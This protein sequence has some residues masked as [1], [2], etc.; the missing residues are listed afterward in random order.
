MDAAI[1]IDWGTSNLRALLFDAHG[2]IRDERERPWGIR[3]LPGGDF[4]RALEDVCD[5][6]PRAPIVASGM[7]G[8]RQGWR[9]ANYV[10]T[11]ADLHA[12]ARH[13]TTFKTHGGRTLAIVPGVRDATKPDVMR[14]EE[15]EIMGALALCPD[16]AAAAQIVLPGTHSKWV[17]VREGKI[18]GFRTMM[19]GEL[20]ALLIRHSILGA[21]IPAGVQPAMDGPAFDAGVRAACAAGNAGALTRIFSARSLVLEK[22]LTPDSVP[23][24]LSGLL[25]G[26]EWRAMSASGWLRRGASLLLVGDARH[27]ALYQRAAT[28]FDLPQPAALNGAAARGLWQIHALS[29]RIDEMAPLPARGH[30]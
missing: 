1:G 19:T 25:I 5:G 8:S 14:G 13:M 30:V 4:E 21:T 24:Y 10:D 20:H 9:E 2:E 16:L 23:S 28:A 3:Q 6:W 17:D 15:T 11:P 18:I 26:E 29:A 27:C 22:Q 12:L 7:V